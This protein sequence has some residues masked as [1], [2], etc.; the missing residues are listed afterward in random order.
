MVIVFSIFIYTLPDIEQTSFTQLKKL[1]KEKV[2]SRLIDKKHYFRW[3]PLSKV[4]RDY[5]YTIVMAE[6]SEF[7]KHSGINYDA[8]VDAMARNYKS[9]SYSYGAS[10]IT[11]QV[12][13]N[14]YLSSNKSIFR[15][16]QEFFITKRL[17]KKFSKNQILEIYFNIAE[18]GPDVYGIRAASYR[19]F[20]KSPNEVNAAEG[21]FISLLLPSPRRYYYSMIQNQNITKKQR[22]K[23]K[24]VLSDMRFM[25][26]ISYKQYKEYLD[27]K[28]F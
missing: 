9:D 13:K 24:R 25:E 23:I 11:Q 10:T 19:I 27:Y 17:E 14:L 2:I 16:L 22:R 1:T 18:F 21:A 3:T 12:A 20:K 15:K 28:Y 26:Y 7:F 8:M 4:N 5:L 6:D